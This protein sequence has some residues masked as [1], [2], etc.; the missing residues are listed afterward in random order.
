M[1]HDY[2]W[3]K[4]FVAVLSLAGSPD[5]IQQR[6]LNAFI[7][8]LIRIRPEEDLPQGIQDEFK[9]LRE[10]LT[11]RPARGNE[12]TAAAT[13]LAMTEEEASKHAETI[14]GLYDSVCRYKKPRV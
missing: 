11:H 2:G 7:S 14:V 9:T 13:I 3:E 1:G 4:L 10:Q 5:T 12:G 8:S 6:L